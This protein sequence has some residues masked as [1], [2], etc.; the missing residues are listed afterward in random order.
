MMLD[1]MKFKRKAVSLHSGTDLS[2]PTVQ[3]AGNNLIAN[4]ILDRSVEL[5]DAGTVCATDNKNFWCFNVENL[6]RP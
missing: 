6:R 3:Y 4:H 5:V 2:V 1:I